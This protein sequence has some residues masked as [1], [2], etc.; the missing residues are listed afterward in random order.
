MSKKISPDFLVGYFSD[1]FDLP[2][3]KA[4][5]EKNKIKLELGVDGS[6]PIFSR[7]IGTTARI[8]GIVHVDILRFIR[9]VYSQYM[10]S[11]TLSLNEVAKEFLEDTKKPFKFKHSSKI[12]EKD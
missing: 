6:Q 7:G 8:K 3:L 9:T 4:R 2:Y 11:E 1:G 10:T 5:A 12:K